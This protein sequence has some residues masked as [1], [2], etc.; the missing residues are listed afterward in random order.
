MVFMKIYL[1]VLPL[2]ILQ[3]QAQAQS[4]V[5]TWSAYDTSSKIL[6][7]DFYSLSKMEVEFTKILTAFKDNRARITLTDGI[8]RIS[9]RELRQPN[10]PL[11]CECS[12]GG[13]TIHITAAMGMM[14]GLGIV[15]SITKDSFV[16]SFFQEADNTD[17]F[18]LRKTDSSYVDRI[19]VSPVKQKLKVF[20]KPLFRNNEIITGQLDAQ[21]KTFYQLDLGVLLTRNYRAKLTF[22]CRLSAH[23]L[24]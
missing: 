3:I 9:P 23:Q 8:N 11:P 16:T 14:S 4:S 22:T 21:F 2:L 7:K 6:A 24:K 19:S 13:G 15:T 5:L 1:A 10:A 20:K 12:T 17:I 18:E